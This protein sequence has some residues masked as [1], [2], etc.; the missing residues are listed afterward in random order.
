MTLPAHLRSRAR[1]AA[2]HG[3]RDEE[4]APG[5]PDHVAAL[6]SSAGN[7]TVQGLF[8]FGKKK[9]PVASP[10]TWQNTQWADTRFLSASSEGSNGVHFAG[11]RDKEVVVKPGE[12]MDV[13]GAV[14]AV[15]DGEVAITIE[16][17][18]LT[19]E[20]DAAGL[21]FTAG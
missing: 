18:R 12:A 7:K 4:R 6:Q 19:I 8:G 1:Q 17:D 9:K 20:A 21:S 13:E 10:L 5:D 3:G 2:R 11:A 14:V 15:L 16:G